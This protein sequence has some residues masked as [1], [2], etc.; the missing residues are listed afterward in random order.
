MRVIG[1]VALPNRLVSAG[2]SMPV[3]AVVS[4]FDLA[5]TLALIPVGLVLAMSVAVNADVHMRPCWVPERQRPVCH[6]VAEL[7]PMAA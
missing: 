5:T 2:L 6:A 7:H 4:V 1:V 3:V